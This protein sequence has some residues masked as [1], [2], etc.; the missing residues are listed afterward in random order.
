MSE[1]LKGSPVNSFSVLNGNPESRYH[2]VCLPSPLWNV[3]IS[4]GLPI[5]TGHLVYKP[6]HILGQF[7]LLELCDREFL[8]P[9]ELEAFS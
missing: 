4:D 8:V 3:P 6:T 1:E 7:G 5:P 9:T 2:A